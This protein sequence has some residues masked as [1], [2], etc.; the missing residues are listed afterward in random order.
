MKHQKRLEKNLI[1]R[2]H[3]FI[4]KEDFQSNIDAGFKS[5]KKNILSLKD[6]HPNFLSE[7]DTLLQKIMNLFEENVGEDYDEKKMGEI[8][9]EGKER[10]DKLIPPGFEDMKKDDDS[11][12]NDLIIWYQIIDYSCTNKK[13]V[14]FITNDSK[15]D[16]WWKAKGKTI[17]PH[18]SLREEFYKKTNCNFYMYSTLQFISYSKIHLA[19][20]FKDESLTEVKN[21][22]GQRH[23]KSTVT[24]QSGQNTINWDELNKLLETIFNNTN[25][26]K[27]KNTNNPD[28][29]EL[30]GSNPQNQ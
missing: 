6:K 1:F 17:M 15:E 10:Y 12:Y 7:E 22:L 16:W 25:T 21:V 28:N 9:K 27:Q 3:P 24:P 11:M 30:S 29:S 23:K 20:E 18:Y 19:A 13:N 5:I 8:I 26:K 4:N 14:I 2:N